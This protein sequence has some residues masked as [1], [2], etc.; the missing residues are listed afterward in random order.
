VRPVFVPDPSFGSFLDRYPR[1]NQYWTGDNIG[2]FYIGAKYNLMSEFRQQPAALALRGMIKLPTGDDDFRGEHRGD[3]LLGRPDREQGS[4]EAGGSL[5]LWRLR[6]ARQPGRLRDPG[7]R[8]PL[9][10]R[11]SAS[12]RATGCG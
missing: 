1:V 11:P 8:V 4:E 3:R 10:R 5:R 9:G 2:D 7:R 6:M 12:R